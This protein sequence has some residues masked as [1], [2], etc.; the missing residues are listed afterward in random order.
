MKFNQDYLTNDLQHR[1][2]L[3][4]EE[5]TENAAR[6][7]FVAV[8]PQRDPDE[9][10]PA[11]R[12]SAVSGVLYGP[13]CLYARTLPTCFTLSG[14]LAPGA[15]AAASGIIPEPCYW[16]EE[17][18]FLYEARLTVRYASGVQREWSHTFGL[19]R[20]EVHGRH[21]RMERR[22]TV[23]RGLASRGVDESILR[24]ARD[25]QAALLAP[26]PGADVLRQADTIGVRLLIDL[27]EG[28][29]GAV[30]ELAAFYWHPS[31]HAVLLS[32]EELQRTDPGGPLAGVAVSDLDVVDGNSVDNGDFVVAVVISGQRP[33][34]TVHAIDKPVIAIRYDDAYVDVASAREAADSLQAELAP[35]FDLAG[36]FAGPGTR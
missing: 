5:A 31:V 13:K 7:A 22:R 15:P 32:R 14:E 3:R 34:A 18:P 30:N 12:I 23:L 6:L 16:T 17:L 1:I 20:L 26:H 28:S 36:Y 19:R 33:P 11:D 2:R 10:D 29:G 4:L 24:Q 25:C 35:E 21:L 9:G 27:R 8:A